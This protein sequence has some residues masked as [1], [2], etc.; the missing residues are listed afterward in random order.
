MTPPIWETLRLYSFEAI[1][2]RHGRPGFSSQSSSTQVNI[3]GPH[4]RIM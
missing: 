2:A 1:I 4:Q 3:S